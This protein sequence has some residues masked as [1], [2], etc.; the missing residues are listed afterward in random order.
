[1]KIGFF[2]YQGITQ[3][4]ITG[5]AQVLSQLPGVEIIL[6]A[7][8]MQPIKTDSGFSINP[9][10][11]FTSVPQ[12]DVVCLPGGPGQGVA[13]K[14]EALIAAIAKQSERAQYVTGVCTGS[15]LLGQA[16]LLRG[17]R[18]ACHWAWREHLT[19]FD[20]IPV[21]ERIVKDR[22]RITGGGVTAG[23]DFAFSLAAELAGEEMARFI[24]LSLEYAP[25]PPFNSGTPELAG[26][27]LTKQVKTVLS[28]LVNVIGLAK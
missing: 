27:E 10:H 9:T 7:K 12:L 22:N 23:I 4:D 19:Q 24:Q 16:G 18:A 13:M 6:L 17:Y 11:H 25:A 8:S 26:P 28:K 2:A 1:M 20:A 5:P 14:D 15:L 21:N 3:L